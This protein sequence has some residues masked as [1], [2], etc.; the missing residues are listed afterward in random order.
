MAQI[1]T[2]YQQIGQSINAKIPE[3]WVSARL[4]VEFKPGVISIQGYY[5]PIQ[6][7]NE[8]VF[9]VGPQLTKLFDELR[10]QLLLAGQPEWNKASF[11]LKLNG[12]FEIKFDY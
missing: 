4:V 2:L 10:T 9:L 6:A 12:T 7:E 11:E 5:L 3:T 1:E 8:K